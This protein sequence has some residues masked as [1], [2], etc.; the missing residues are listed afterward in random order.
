MSARIS[1]DKFFSRASMSS[2]MQAF[3][4]E[5]GQPF[6]Y[7]LACSGGLEL[8][9]YRPCSQSRSP[10][11]PHRRGENYRHPSHSVHKSTL[12]DASERVAVTGLRAGCELFFLRN[13]G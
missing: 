6:S 8:A 11:P 10:D 4:R 1:S 13:R 7:V 9:T 12:S 5:R 3:F 2:G